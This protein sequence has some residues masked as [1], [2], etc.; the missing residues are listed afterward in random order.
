MFDTWMMTPIDGDGVYG[1]G[2]LGADGT[3]QPMVL[4]T[5]AETQQQVSKV[6]RLRIKVEQG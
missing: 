6:D 1:S 3:E 2:A 4:E 5:K